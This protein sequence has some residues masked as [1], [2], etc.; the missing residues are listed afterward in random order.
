MIVRLRHWRRSLATL[1]S[2]VRHF[3]FYALRA[4]PAF[5]M[6]ARLRAWRG[7]GLANPASSSPVLV[8]ISRPPAPPPIRSQVVPGAGQSSRGFVRLRG[9]GAPSVF[10]VAPNGRCY[11][12]FHAHRFPARSA[13]RWPFSGLATGTYMT[14]LTLGFAPTRE[15]SAAR[16]RSWIRSRASRSPDGCTTYPSPPLACDTPR[17]SLGACP[18]G[19]RAEASS[20]A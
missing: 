14:L 10:V 12:P 15:G 4:A 9:R 3:F 11:P 16:V 7:A 18:A 20:S 17:H 13:S 19:D 5:S 2:C 8:P 6:K 1:Q